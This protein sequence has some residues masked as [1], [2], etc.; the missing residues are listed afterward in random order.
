MREARSTT[1]SMIVRVLGH[2]RSAIPRPATSAAVVSMFGV[3]AMIGASGRSRA[4]RSPVEPDF[5][6]HTM[7]RAWM[8]CRDLV[9]GRHH[10]VE[11]RRFRLARSAAIR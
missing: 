9:H 2:G 7:A 3:S 4:A 5:V 1:S 6:Q 8:V 11:R 10:R